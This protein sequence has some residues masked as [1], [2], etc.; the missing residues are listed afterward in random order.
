MEKGLT[1][2]AGQCPVQ[3]Y[4]HMLLGMIQARGPG[5]RGEEPSLGAL[6][7]ARRRRCLPCSRATRGSAGSSCAAGSPPLH[8]HKAQ[9]HI[10]RTCRP[11]VPCPG[12][13][14]HKQFFLLLSPPPAAGGQAGPLLCD[15]A[16]PPPVPGSR[17]VQDVQQQDGGL[18]QGNHGRDPC[19]L[20]ASACLC[21]GMVQPCNPALPKPACGSAAELGSAA[22]LRLHHA[23][24]MQVVMKAGAGTAAQ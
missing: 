3:R 12:P 4:W 21:G 2:K 17:G 11:L 19:L 13:T 5:G 16:P 1:M 7:S 8:R 9:A 6:P 20:S 23:H 10:T 24:G 18:H 14:P 22:A 15:H